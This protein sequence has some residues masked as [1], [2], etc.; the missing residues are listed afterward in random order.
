[1]SKKRN[2]S[3][4]REIHQKIR[5]LKE[6]LEQLQ[7]MKQILMAEG[8]K[9]DLEDK[10]KESKLIQQLL[11]LEKDLKRLS[12]GPQAAKPTPKIPFQKAKARQSRPSL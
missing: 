4:E 2:P 8:I 5:Q 12:K 9:P 11:G 1:M 6:K 7:Q 10:Q 3:S